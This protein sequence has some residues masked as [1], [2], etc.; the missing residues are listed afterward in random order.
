MQRVYC[1]VKP[2]GAEGPRAYVGYLT[3]IALSTLGNLAKNLGP[4]LGT[5]AFLSGGIAPRHIFPCARLCTG[6]PW[7]TVVF[8]RAKYLFLYLYK[9]TTSHY[10]FSIWIDGTQYFVGIADNNN[11]LFV[12]KSSVGRWGIFDTSL[13]EIFATLWGSHIS[14]HLNF[15]ILR[16]FC[17]LTHFNFALLSETHCFFVNFTQ[18]VPK[19]DQT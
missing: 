5:F 16:K 19:L 18:H 2:E 8:S 15:A 13:H 6:R 4:R 12:R 9:N 10:S 1:N 11:S 14:R 3:S 17:I 7:K